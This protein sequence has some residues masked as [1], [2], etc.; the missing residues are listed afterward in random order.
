MTLEGFFLKL[1][2][3][4][5]GSGARLPLSPVLFIIFMNDLLHSLHKDCAQAG[6]TAFDQRPYVS[7]SFADDTSALAEGQ[8]HENMQTI[9][10]AMHAHS[11][12]WLWNANVMKSHVMAMQMLDVIP[13]NRS[14]FKWGSDDLPFA[15][16]TE[17]LGVWINHDLSWKEH[18]SHVKKTGWLKLKKYK[19]FYR[20]R[21]Y[22]CVQ[23]Y[24]QF[25]QRSPP[26]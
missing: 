6:V 9:I 2:R 1:L 12:E 17:K 26:H 25:A 14:T 22:T 15:D 8:K 5:A 13:M 4:Q 7:Q 24:I 20:A 18:I 10:T 3:H 23:N 11:E 21:K 16:K 19:K